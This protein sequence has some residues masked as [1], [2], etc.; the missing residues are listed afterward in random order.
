MLLLICTMG[1]FLGLLT[2]LGSVGGRGGEPWQ[3]VAP[4]GPGAGDGDGDGDDDDDDDGDDDDDDG[5]EGVAEM[6]LE[7]FIGTFTH[8]TPIGKTATTSNYIQNASGG[9]E[10][11]WRR[12][13]WGC[14]V[15]VVGVPVAAGVV[16]GSVDAHKWLATCTGASGN[17]RPQVD[18]VGDGRLRVW[19]GE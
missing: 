15:M 5:G 11:L 17:G 2:S 1:S 9:V 6:K 18:G 16:V 8:S 7:G 10:G 4:S 14:G 3:A 12:W 13:W 19:L